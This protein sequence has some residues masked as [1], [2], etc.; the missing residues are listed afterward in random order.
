VSRIGKLAIALP[1]GVDVKVEGPRVNVKGPKG[2]LSVDTVGRVNVKVEDGKVTVARFDDERQSRA[3]HGLYQRLIANSVAGVTKGYRK[4]LEIQGV[5]YRAAVQGKKLTLALGYSHP[6]EFDPP[7]GI[8]ITSAK[9]TEIVIEGA[10]KQQVG[11]VAA[12]IRNFRPP[13]PYKGKGI[14]YKGEFVRRK[15]G[16]KAA[17]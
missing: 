17:K 10:D 7:A 12:D 3:Y 5:G 16:K 11:Q 4:E 9:Q 13:E 15:V 8:T 14:R 2:T 6:I 1:K